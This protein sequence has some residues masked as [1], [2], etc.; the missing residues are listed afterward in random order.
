M[1]RLQFVFQQDV[2]Q[3]ESR[4][5]NA[6]GCIVGNVGSNI[7]GAWPTLGTESR[8]IF[9]SSALILIFL[10]F[11]YTEGGY[12]SLEN[13]FNVFLLL[14]LYIASSSYCLSVLPASKVCK[15]VR[16]TKFRC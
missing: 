6:I 2:Y 14:K 4:K 11:Y 10:F 1:W 8:D 5:K 9:V 13:P 12:K 3:V 15:P 7:F 16:L